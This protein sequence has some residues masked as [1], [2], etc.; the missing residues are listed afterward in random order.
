[1]L[2]GSAKLDARVAAELTRTLAPH[3]TVYLLGG[4]QAL[5]PQVEKDVAALGF[6]TKR[7]A[8]TDRYSTAVRIAQEISA[9]P[10]A[11]LIATATN[12]PDALA[13]GA[14]AA[15]NAGQVP[16]WSGVVV[17]TDGAT[18]PAATRAYLSGFSPSATLVFGVGGAAVKAADTLP[19]YPD[20]LTP[21]AGNDRYETAAEVAD[22]R[23]LFG[24][25]P[26]Q[27]P[28]KN[29]KFAGVAT[30]ID[31][32][33][34][35]SGGALVGALH[36]PLLLSDGSGVP[37]DELDRLH[38]HSALLSLAI[39]GGTKAVSNSVVTQAGNVAW[40]AGNWDSVAG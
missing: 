7:L 33:D 11:I 30:G 4:P 21:L 15:A 2:T 31:W 28:M 3:S 8:G 16:G 27:G 18:M 13:A 24:N 1:M 12:Y 26:V 29:V 6:T 23:V 39:F 17:L 10:A 32:P 40:G 14:A 35:L 20:T 22:S 9:K 37:A 38:F 36:G 34:A 19:G 5:S 25:A